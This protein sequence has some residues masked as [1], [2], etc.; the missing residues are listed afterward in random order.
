MSAT[1]YAVTSGEYSDYGV[2]LIFEAEDDAVEYCRAKGYDVQ[3]SGDPGSGMWETKRRWDD[4]RVEPMQ[5]WRA[6][7]L[8]V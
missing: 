4:F 2:H 8:P 1:V 6:G 7:E 3:P 5:F